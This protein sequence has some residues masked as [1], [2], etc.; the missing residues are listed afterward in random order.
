MDL[1]CSL[2]RL[3]RVA[4]IA[5]IAVLTL[6]GLAA[7][8]DAG[9]P[10]AR[11][12]VEWRLAS[13]FP[14]SARQLG[15]LGR[16]LAEKV[17]AISGG[18]FRL[19]FVEPNVLVEPFKLFDA[20]AKEQVEAGWATPAYWY[21]KDPAFALFSSVPFGP[22]AMEFL[23]WIR[24]GGGARLRD[25]LYEPYGLV[26]IVCGAMAPEA[27]GWYRRQ[28]T[29]V[30]DFRGLKMRAFGLGGQ[31]LQHLGIE[32]QLV[33]PD[34][35]LDSLADG[36]LDAAEFSMPAIDLGV[37]FHKVAKLYYYF[38]GWHQ[39]TTLFE[40]LVG[41][42]TWLALSEAQRAQ[43]RTTCGDNIQE[44]IAEGEAIQSPAI[45]AMRQSGVEIRRFPPQVLNGLE[46]GWH[47]VAS[48]LS[49]KSANFR[50]IWT[51]LTRFREE[52]RVWRE[53]GYIK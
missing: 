17:T 2:R 15:T 28:I 3:Q 31:V 6:P 9:R 14:G 47:Q 7:A 19:T 4:A 29:S 42:G 38:P 1:H 33:A 34:K 51:D 40:L 11:K 39:Q 48:K 16:S 26:S 5:G 49:Q 20:V 22:D 23:A 43:L 12:P 44:G 36:A 8:A 27:G 53:L 35:L 50:R 32:P 24:H 37:G 52:Y 45:L 18:T 46:K 10:A 21:D 41:R 25:E 13:A 30:A